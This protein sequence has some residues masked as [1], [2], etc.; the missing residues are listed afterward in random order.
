[1]T[2]WAGQWPDLQ[3]G[4]GWTSSTLESHHLS[5]AFH[6]VLCLMSARHRQLTSFHH[7]R[8]MTND[9]VSW[10]LLTSLTYET[11]AD[12]QPS[13]VYDGLFI[14]SETKCLLCVTWSQALEIPT[15][16]PSFW[17]KW[18]RQLKFFGTCRS[19]SWAEGWIGANPSD[20]GGGEGWSGPN[21][22]CD[23]RKDTGDHDAF[24]T[25][26]SAWLDHR[27]CVAERRLR[28]EAGEVGRG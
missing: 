17:P 3:L 4:R 22:Q 5:K 20:K 8:K 1:M 10:P 14:G 2:V 12:H 25:C 24:G 28:E 27:L 16:K 13:F 19:G 18:T 26:M 23:L 21:A 11:W 15:G 7:L 9:Y 6:G